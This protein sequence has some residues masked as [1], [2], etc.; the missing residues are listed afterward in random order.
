[1]THHVQV[2][3]ARQVPV[4][5]LCLGRVLVRVQGSWPAAGRV[6]ARRERWVL[7]PVPCLER[8]RARVQG[9]WPA[10][11]LQAHRRGVTG[12]NPTSHASSI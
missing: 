5:G 2:Q 11:D 1:M 9:S 8:V 4:R 7:A 3:K 10:A 12:W 6:R